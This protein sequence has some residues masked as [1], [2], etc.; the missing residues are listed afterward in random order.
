MEIL[1]N[2]DNNSQKGDKMSKK[3]L[4]KEV[5]KL[6]EAYECPH[7]KKVLPGLTKALLLRYDEI[8][9]DRA[10]EVVERVLK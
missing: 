5:V 10:R 1:Y 3:E 9:Y 6:M 2:F 7:S 8:S 4:E